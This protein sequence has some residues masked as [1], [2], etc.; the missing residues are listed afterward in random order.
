[1]FDTCIFVHVCVWG[2]AYVHDC[3][4]VWVCSRMSIYEYSVFMGKRGS[5][6]VCMYPLAFACRSMC[7]HVCICVYVYVHVYICIHVC[8]YLHIHTCDFVMC[9]HPLC[10]CIRYQDKENIFCYLSCTFPAL[11]EIVI[12]IYFLFYYANMLNCIVW[13][14]LVISN[15]VISWK[16]NLHSVKLS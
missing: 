11:I 9:R 14:F 4:C 6:C 5:V 8:V 1:M 10:H 13:D 16:Y 3:V 12:Y 15:A 2:C 7:V